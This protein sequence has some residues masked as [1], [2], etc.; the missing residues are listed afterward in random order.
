MGHEGKME[1]EDL[2]L[3]LEIMCKGITWFSP[4][5]RAKANHN[6][7]GNRQGCRTKTGSV[8]SK[9]GITV[10]EVLE[11]Q[12]TEFGDKFNVFHVIGI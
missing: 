6:K 2:C 11:E 9:E 4:G 5:G 1:V 12:A 7:P 10:R 3:I 8:S